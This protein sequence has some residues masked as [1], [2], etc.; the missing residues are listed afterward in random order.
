MRDFPRNQAEFESRFSSEQACRQY[1]FALRWPEGFV[2]PRC[3]QSGGWLTKRGLVMCRRCGYQ[4]SLTAGTI[5]QGS[6]KPLQ[7][8]FRAIWALTADKGGASA[9]AVQRLLELGSYQTAWTWLHKLRRAMVRPDQDRLSGRVEVDETYFGGR[10]EGRPGRSPDTKALIVI[11]AEEDGRKIGRIRMQKVP[12]ASAKSLQ[13]F[14][15]R[16][17]ESGSVIHTDGWVGYK[18]L[19]A[20]GYV[21][22]PTAQGRLDL[23]GAGQDLLPRAHRVSSLLR[24]WV[25][26]THQ[27]AV[28]QD[29]LDYYLDEFTFRFNRRTSRSRGLLFLRLLEN[30]VRLP[31]ATYRSMAR[32][33]RGPPKRGHNM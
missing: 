27:G 13:G 22:E 16:V 24:R 19:A 30:A 8:W 28:S 5:F 15:A 4:A 29:H 14:I 25:M 33:Q 9:L 20:K 31:T 18:G 21:H 26:G 1:L 17:V 32:G 3:A 2:C 7:T 6:R 11:A 10:A 12:D 23:P